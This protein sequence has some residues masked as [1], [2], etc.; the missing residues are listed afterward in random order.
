MNPFDYVD[1]ISK[2]KKNLM[3][4]SD[5]DELSEKAYTPYIVNKALSYFPDTL[6]YANEINQ[7]G[8]I[9]HKLQYEYLLHSI[10]VGKRFSKWTK[11]ID[12]PEIDAIARY[13]QINRRRA[14]EYA[15]LLTEEE[16]EDLV[17][18]TK[19]L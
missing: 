15:S 3:R 13:Y 8:H 4:D 7:L 2:S 1:S 10:R 12:K 18:K 16:C 6:L 14:E 9:D 17:K 19:D 11:K 5:N